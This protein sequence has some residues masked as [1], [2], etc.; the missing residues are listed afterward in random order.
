MMNRRTVLK[1]AVATAGLVA[2]PYE[3]R[4]SPAPGRPTPRL[5]AI[6]HLDKINRL[7]GPYARQGRGI[8]RGELRAAAKILARSGDTLETRYQQI[9]HLYQL[10]FEQPPTPPQ[11]ERTIEWLSHVARL[12]PKKPKHHGWLRPSTA[13]AQDMPDLFAWS[14]ANTQ[15]T[16][17][18]A[19]S[20]IAVS[21]EAAAVAF[22]GSSIM[23]D[24]LPAIMAQIVVAESG[25]EIA[26]LSF[27][28]VAV[29]FAGLGLIALGIGAIILG[30][31][32]FD[33]YWNPVGSLP[34]AEYAIPFDFKAIG[35]PPD[36]N[37]FDWGPSTP[38]APWDPTDQSDPNYDPHYDP[39]SPLYDP[40][41]GTCVSPAWATMWCP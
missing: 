26:A 36:P 20:A 19:A 4:G 34:E 29:T 16:G 8:S 5:Y 30:V 1:G 9:A 40:D 12:T 17:L 15:M 33:Q 7:V 35:V 25:M 23:L 14:I 24:A 3:L 10:A 31:N 38:V 39:T 21:A 18:A 27:G 37:Q 2:L 11:I 22:E 6:T 28:Y 41:W 13:A 32:I